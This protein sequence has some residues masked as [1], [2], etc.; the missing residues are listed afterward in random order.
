MEKKK[1][2]KNKIRREGGAHR[3]TRYCVDQIEFSLFPTVYLINS[4]NHTQN[5]MWERR[6]F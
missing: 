1:R 5:E 3:G 4:H 2:R 6:R